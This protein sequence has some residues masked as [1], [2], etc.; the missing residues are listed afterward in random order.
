[1][2]GKRSIHAEHKLMSQADQIVVLV[3]SSKFNQRGSLISAPLS[4]VDLLITDDGIDV[5]SRK[6]LDDAG[7]ETQILEVAQQQDA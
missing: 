4:K 7:V 1:M 5:K 2:A 6:M 3:D